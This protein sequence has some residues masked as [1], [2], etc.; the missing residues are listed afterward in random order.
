MLHKV[1]S[2]ISHTVA[3]LEDDI[4]IALYDR[5]QRKA[6]L[7]PAGREVLREGRRI[8]RAVSEL[9]SKAH[10]AADGWEPEFTIVLDHLLPLRLLLPALENF[11]ERAPEVRVNVQRESLDGSWDALIWRRADLAIG[12]GGMGPPS[13]ECHAQVL[14]E[15]AMVYAAAP[16]HPL[17]ALPTPLPIE[18]LLGH[19]YVATA[20]TARV[21]Q[22]RMQALVESR[23]QLSLVD[24]RDKLEALRAGLGFGLLPQSL[25]AIEISAG[26]LVELHP[27]EAAPALSV[28]YASRRQASGKALDWFV[29]ALGQ[30]GS[31]WLHQA[32]N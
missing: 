2:A 25:A 19:R 32:F 1:R 22:P 18:T 21:A 23:L 9:E 10:Y 30:S 8:L 13:G 12:A 31:V 29:H 11:A 14:G 27:V 6:E 24:L 7:T 16:N 3:K 26:R 17:A 20:D 4:G 15:L 5:S 28:Q